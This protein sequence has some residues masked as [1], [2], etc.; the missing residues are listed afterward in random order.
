MRGGLACAAHPAADTVYVNRRLAVGYR[1][2]VGA[3]D[4]GLDAAVGRGASAAVILD[5]LRVSPV[6]RARREQAGVGALGGVHYAAAL[7]V[8]LQPLAGERM[9]L[10]PAGRLA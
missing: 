1:G 9:E 2:A 4:V 10:H 7:G 6:R 8:M 3:G 5:G